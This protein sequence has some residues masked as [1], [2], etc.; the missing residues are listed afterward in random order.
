M[1]SLDPVTLDIWWSRVTSIVDEM[2]AAVQRTAFSAVVREANDYCCTLLDSRG[3]LIAQNTRAIPSFIGTVSNTVRE[4]MKVFPPETLA[5][6]DVIITN[7]PWI[8]SGHLPDLTMALP[9]FV[10][11]KLVGFCGLVFHL[12]DIGG[13]G[14]AADTKDFY[15]E[16]LKVPVVKLC[17]AG[18]MDTMVTDFIKSNVRIPDQV[19]GDIEAAITAA[20]TGEARVMQFMGEYG[21]KDLD[22]LSH[23]VQNVSE[24]AMR[25][26]IDKVPDGTYVHEVTGDGWDHP[27]TIRTTVI[28]DGDTIKVD[29]DGTSIQSGY[30]INSVFNYTYAY[31]LY[32]LKCAIC[33]AVPNNEGT[34]RPFEIVVPEGT[35]LNPTFPAPVSARF[36][37]GH[38]I[39][40][41]IFGS[42][43]QAVPE[44]VNAENSAPFWG[45]LIHG[46]REDG[47]IYVAPNLLYNGG[48]G[49]NK[50]SD[51]ISCLC[52][53]SNVG[54]APIET[55]ETTTGLMVIEKEFVA[56][57]GGAGTRRGGLGQKVVLESV[58]DYPTRV[59]LLTD[60]IKN[61]AKGYGGGGNGHAGAIFLND[62]PIN[63]PKG[64]VVLNK[65]DRITLILP[66]GGGYGSPEGRS[67]DKIAEDIENELVSPDAARQDY[68]F[69][70]KQHSN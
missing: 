61:P 46:R 13:R 9:I 38:F 34:C 52:I 53:P 45:L 36:L 26:A 31:T 8:A 59:F 5:A 28:V 19:M 6:D 23:A 27:L 1:A 65:G 43:A 3:D 16:G 60:R 56:D 21:L 50:L 33:P 7:D 54:S 68:D 42:L 18:V 49:A 37:S 32:A 40:A 12:P 44:M 70:V 10:D 48:Q 35:C 67:T 14:G 24:R 22:D 47:S 62:V 4:F 17:R 55:I 2:A 51:G 57:S 15:E 20:K 69:K 39:Q 58:S 29:Y 41:A 66:G 11:N 25:G 63:E 30:G 64:E